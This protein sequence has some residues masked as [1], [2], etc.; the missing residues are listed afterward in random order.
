MKENQCNNLK[1]IILFFNLYF[2][3]FTITYAG[4]LPETILKI[5]ILTN[6]KKI[7]LGSE[8]EYSI[9]DLTSGQNEIFSDRDIHLVY[10]TDKGIIIGDKKIPSSIIRIVP[11]QDNKFIR[12]N[13]KRYRDSIII[14]KEKNKTLTVI[15]EVGLENYVAGVLPYEIDSG[16]KEEALKAQAVV[17]RTYASRNLKK[18]ESEEYDLCNTVHC[19]VYGGVDGEKKETNTA[20]ERTRG[21]VLTYKGDLANTFYHACCG[22]HTEKP[23]YVWTTFE[24]NPEYLKGVKCEFCINSKHYNWAN[25]VDESFIRKKLNENGYKNIARILNINFTGKT[26]SGRAKYVRIYYKDRTTG[27]ISDIKINSASFRLAI[28]PLVIKSTKFLSIKKLS[29]DKFRFV[30]KGWGHGVGMC[31]WGS[32]VMADK[33]YNYK[34]ILRYYYP[35][36]KI[37]KWEE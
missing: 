8:T 11:K 4:R 27:K 19:Q 34:A 28:D 7:N 9:Y 26:K 35:E 29:K 1:F 6:Q 18:H 12:I 14:R 16:W 33:G 3:L 37:E 30:G 15:N 36:T 2:S 22:G 10:A 24:D 20:V 5:S 31:Q 17:A 21:E 23:L 25:D 13:G 32:K